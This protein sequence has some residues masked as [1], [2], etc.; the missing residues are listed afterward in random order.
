[1]SPVVSKYLTLTIKRIDLHRNDKELEKILEMEVE[2][3][4]TSSHYRHQFASREDSLRLLI[5][6]ERELFEGPVDIKLMN[7]YQYSYRFRERVIPVS[8][9]H[10]CTKLL[11]T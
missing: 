5:V 8:A 1:M 10:I 6:K 4:H 9:V 7:K 2:K 3:S 11:C